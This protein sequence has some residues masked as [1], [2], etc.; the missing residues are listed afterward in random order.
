MSDLSDSSKN[1]QFGG[2]SCNYEVTF[3]SD[4][5]QFGDIFLLVGDN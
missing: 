4:S 1:L 2:F 5:L 3:S